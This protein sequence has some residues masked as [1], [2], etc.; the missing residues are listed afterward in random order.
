MLPCTPWKVAY[1]PRQR[2]GELLELVGLGERASHLPAQLS[3]GEQQRLCIARAL[4]NHPVMLLADEPTGNPDEDSARDVIALIR[5]IAGQNGQ[6]EPTGTTDGPGQGRYEQVVGRV[7]TVRRY[8]AWGLLISVLVLT[9]CGAPGVPTP[10]QAELPDKIAEIQMENQGLTRRVETL[11][12]ENDEL[13]R[14]LAAGPGVGQIKVSR[15]QAEQIVRGNAQDWEVSHVSLVELML[16]DPD[17]WV[18]VWLFVSGECPRCSK[19]IVDAM[20]GQVLN[21]TNAP[22]GQ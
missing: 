10:A 7:L 1:N 18:A 12:R 14:Q 13:K 17:R 8:S 6:I 16:R 3:G 5:S 4:I 19:R 20:T 9:G 2:A 21:A 11:Q 22:P 15:E